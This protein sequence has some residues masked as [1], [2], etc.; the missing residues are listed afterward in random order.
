MNI[1]A[2]DDRPV[3]DTTTGGISDGD[4]LE[5]AF[6]E[7]DESDMP[8]NRLYRAMDEYLTEMKAREHSHPAVSLSGGHKLSDKH[9][10]FKI[11]AVHLD[12]GNRAES[13]AECEY[14]RRWVDEVKRATT[15][16]DDYERVS[17]EIRY[18][19]YADADGAAERRSCHCAG[20]E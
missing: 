9:G 7:T 17:R 8:R 14:V 13:G 1:F 2:N 18:W 15:K 12:Y 10:G 19:A 5:R 4:I 20:E 11:V 6:T 16:R 3:T